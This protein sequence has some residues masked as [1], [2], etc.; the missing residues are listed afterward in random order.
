MLQLADYLNELE[1]IRKEKADSDLIDHVMPEEGEVLLL[2]IETLY[3]CG[4]HA[5]A[6]RILLNHIGLLNDSLPDLLSMFIDQEE[7]YCLE[8]GPDMMEMAIKILAEIM[9]R[10][11]WK[12]DSAIINFPPFHETPRGLYA[13]GIIAEILMMASNDIPRKVMESAVR[14]LSHSDRYVVLSTLVFI[15]SWYSGGECPGSFFLEGYLREPYSFS[16]EDESVKTLLLQIQ[17]LRVTTRY[18]PY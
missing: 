8:M 9:Q 18:P 6:H 5:D 13:G 3:F 10:Y 17:K 15:H 14:F 2:K 7:Y 16:A 4:D 1:R 11:G 12:G